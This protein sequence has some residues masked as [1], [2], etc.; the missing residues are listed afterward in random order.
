[1]NKQALKQYRIKGICTVLILIIWGGVFSEVISQNK[2]V[3][4]LEALAFF[5]TLARHSNALIIDTRLAYEYEENRMKDAVLAVSQKELL[6]VVKDQ[7]KDRPLFVYCEFGDRSKRAAKV[8][9]ANGFTTV[10]DLKGGLVVWL[11]Q[12]FEIDSTFYSFDE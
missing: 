12:G 9:V 5:E 6:K 3:Q 11:D 8:L 10:F 2:K 7:P 1:M 4:R